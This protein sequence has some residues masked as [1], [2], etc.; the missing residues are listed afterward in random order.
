MELERQQIAMPGAMQKETNT[1]TLNVEYEFLDKEA[2]SSEVQEI[3][4]PAKS[5]SDIQINIQNSLGSS[6]IRNFT[7]EIQI[8]DTEEQPSE[9][10]LVKR[11]RSKLI[12]EEEV[13]EKS[14]KV[15]VSENETVVSRG[16]PATSTIS[17]NIVNEN[18]LTAPMGSERSNEKTSKRIQRIIS[19]QKPKNA[20][21]KS[22]GS[23]HDIT[24]KHNSS[25]GI[26][27]TN[28]S[29]RPAMIDGNQNTTKSKPFIELIK[30]MSNS[31]VFP[32]TQEAMRQTS[33][34]LLV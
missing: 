19:Q 22:L 7:C 14:R 32:S 23:F 27:K 16:V 5:K 6:S 2:T 1:R 17:H 29:A 18:T 11:R 28:D 20:V 9:S 34:S 21:I 31:S 24:S 12:D 8:Q 4:N 26:N 10:N 3:Y 30:E 13:D 25:E 15:I 33:S